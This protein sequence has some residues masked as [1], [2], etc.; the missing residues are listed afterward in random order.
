MGWLTSGSKT[1]LIAQLS[2]TDSAE[3]RINK[4]IAELVEE[5]RLNTAL[6]T[7]VNQICHTRDCNGVYEKKARTFTKYKFFSTTD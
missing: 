7:D 2:A 6:S 5:K 1:K 3:S 4:R